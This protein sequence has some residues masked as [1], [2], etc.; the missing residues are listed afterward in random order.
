MDWLG[1]VGRHWFDLRH[2]KHPDFCDVS[3][4]TTSEA[5]HTHGRHT[6]GGRC[7]LFRGWSAWQGFIMKG[8]SAGQPRAVSKTS[9]VV[10]EQ[11]NVNDMSLFSKSVCIDMKCIPDYGFRLLLIIVAKTDGDQNF[12][13]P[14]SDL[15]YELHWQLHGLKSLL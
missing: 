13:S 11:G 5:T 10:C 2:K 1:L 4:H 12:I 9:L 6:C 7:Q 15:Q 3:P 14:A 8:V